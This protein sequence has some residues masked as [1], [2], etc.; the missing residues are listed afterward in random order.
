LF[1]SIV[2]GS[3]TWTLLGT[4]ITG[5][6]KD[7]GA[8]QSILTA[9]YLPIVLLSGIFFPIS[10]EPP[11]MQ[12]IAKLLPAQP[13][14]HA[15][16]LSISHGDSLSGIWMNFSVL[17]IWAVIGFVIAIKSFRWE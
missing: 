16:E 4:A 17:I 12:T 6:I 2:L 3:L 14:A 1:I 8:G 11:W 15:I 5:F 9:T 7:T 10:S 13:L